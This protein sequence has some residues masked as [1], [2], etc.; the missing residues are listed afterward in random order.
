MQNN[1][2]SSED[3]LYIESD[4]ALEDL[5]HTCMCDIISIA[6]DSEF[7]R[8]DKDSPPKLALLQFKTNSVKGVIDPLKCSNTKDF[9]EFIFGNK[10]II[11]IMHDGKQDL[12]TFEYFYRFELSEDEIFDTQIAELFTNYYTNGTPSYK[13]LVQKYCN[14]TINKKYQNSNWIKRPLTKPQIEYAITDVEYLHEIY[15]AQKKALSE[16]KREEVFRNFMFKKLNNHIH[17]V[18]THRNTEFLTDKQ[19]EIINSIHR[20]LCATCQTEKISPSVIASKNDIRN[21]LF[22]EEEH[23]IEE[24]KMKFLKIKPNSL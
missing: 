21:I 9:I 22:S 1:P 15:R 17:K 8:F 10:S 5:I 19:K 23:S 13:E 11:K 12:E 16:M 3:F 18:K 4:K 2:S 20:N 14:K 6:I 24:W 7:L